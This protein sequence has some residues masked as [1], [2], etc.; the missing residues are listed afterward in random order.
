MTAGLPILMV[1]GLQAEARIA[2]HP[3]VVTLVGGGDPA[4]LALLLQGALAPG[5]RAVISFGIAGGLAPGLRPGTVLLA[6]SVHDGRERVAT[7]R[8]WLKR[9]SE[10]LPDAR[11]VHLAG[12][13]RV[14]SG[15][16]AKRALHRDTGAAAVDMESH[17]AARLANLHRIPFAALRVVADPA[18]RTL[19][20]AATVGMRADGSTDAPAVLRSLLDRPGDIPAL[21]RTALDARAAFDGLRRSRARLHSL[22]GSVEADADQHLAATPFPAGLDGPLDGIGTTGIGLRPRT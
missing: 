10:S 8:D 3:G 11:T 5:A 19:P 9:L 17:V 22:L 20:R 13:D 6:C 14:V 15:T 1:S 12:A 4:R 7:D 18:E 2:R 21:I 16:E